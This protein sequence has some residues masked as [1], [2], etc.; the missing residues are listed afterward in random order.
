MPVT[1]VRADRPVRELGGTAASRRSWPSGCTPSRT[2]AAAVREIGVD[3]ATEMCERLLAEGVPGLHFIT[4][5]WSRA[6][7]EIY[8]RLGLAERAARMR[9]SRQDGPE[10]SPPGQAAS[11]ADVAQRQ[12][13]AHHRVGRVTAGEPVRRQQ[14]DEPGAAVQLPRR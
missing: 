8:E 11:G 5:N 13:G 7:R 4:L 2:T 3:Y 1:N 10:R 6:T 12:R 9:A 14:V